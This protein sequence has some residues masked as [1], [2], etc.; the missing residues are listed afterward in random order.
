MTLVYVGIALGIIGLIVEMGLDYRRQAAELAADQ[1]EIREQT[2]NHLKKTQE[3]RG[4]TVTVSARIEKL[5]GEKRSLQKELNVKK[6]V[7][8]ESEEDVRKRNPTKFLFKPP[9]EGL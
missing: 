4:K 6:Q 5:E 3:L 9:E 1:D 2:T 7:L 8:K